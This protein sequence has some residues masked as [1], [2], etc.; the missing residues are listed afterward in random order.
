MTAKSHPRI[1]IVGDS[2][3]FHR[4]PFGQKLEECWPL[5][6]KELVPQADVW[7]RSRPAILVKKVVEEFAQFEDSLY[8]FDYVVVQSGI[9][10]SCPR[11]MPHFMHV[12]LGWIGSQFLKKVINKNYKILLKIYCRCWTSEKKYRERLQNLVDRAAKANSKLKVL[13]V[14]ILPSCKSLAEKVPQSVNSIPRYNSIIE[15][16][17]SSAP[18]AK[19]LKKFS[20]ALN[21]D[22]IIEDGHH[23]NATGH[24][25]L[26]KHIV[27]E[28]H[29]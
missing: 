4:P 1:L 25:L 2:L 23:L 15:E 16:L 3:A 12:F 6:L 8:L 7:V 28:M 27:E 10:D 21:E 18:N 19:F 29:D 14:P 26:A 11:P 20:L 9:N 24:H 5:K 13:F 22:L 17:C